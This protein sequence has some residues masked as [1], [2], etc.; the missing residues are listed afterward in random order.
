MLFKAYLRDEV[1]DYV[2]NV[3]QKTSKVLGSARGAEVDLL[4]H[5]HVMT[6]KG[7]LQVFKK[8]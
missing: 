6:F 7:Y 5:L 4:S 8:S 1:F 3:A 2:F